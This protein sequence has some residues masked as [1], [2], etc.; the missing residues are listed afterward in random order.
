MSLAEKAYASIYDQL[1]HGH[2]VPNQ[3]LSENELA[4]ELEMSRTPIRSALLRLENEGFVEIQSNRGILVKDI[5]MIELIETTAVLNSFIWNTI[6]LV[7]KKTIQLDMK[8]LGLLLEI[9]EEGKNNNHY[10]QYMDAYNDFMYELIESS[11]NRV[12]IQLFLEIHV[13]IKRAGI[14][15]HKFNTSHYTG[16]THAKRIYAALQQEDFERIEDILNNYLDESKQKYDL[17]DE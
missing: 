6:Q 9:M 14:L 5:S 10:L 3:R 17:F 7:K 2:Y 4:K 13:K 12:M 11:T 16:F 15:N 1:I 8:R